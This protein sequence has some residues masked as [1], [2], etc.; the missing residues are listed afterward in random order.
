MS[1]RHSLVILG[2]CV[3]LSFP[4]GAQAPKAG[5]YDV[6]SR[7][8]WQKSPFPPGMQSAP[9]AEQPHTR[10]ACVSQEQI[11]K[12]NGPKPQGGGGCQVTNIRKQPNGLT[13]ELSCGA[14][15]TGKGTVKTIWIDS[16][17]SKTT[18]HFTG[19]M[20]I[21]EDTKPVEWTLE[22]ESRYQASDCGKL[23]PLPE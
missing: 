17:H 3:F 4:I 8:T 9:G 12:Y 11:D 13:A 2:S 7:M 20:K 21:G 15:I 18:V 6:T 1:T 19:S 16:G 23:K 22:S 10:P 5:L 14:P